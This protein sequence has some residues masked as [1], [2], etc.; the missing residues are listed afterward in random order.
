MQKTKF[1]HLRIYRSK[2]KTQSSKLRLVRVRD[3]RQG[4]KFSNAIKERGRL[5]PLFWL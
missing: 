4:W 3:C 1:L 2:I 5:V